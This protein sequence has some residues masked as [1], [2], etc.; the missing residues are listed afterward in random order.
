MY[1]VKDTGLWVA[2]ATESE[3]VMATY[4]TTKVK[5]EILEKKLQCVFKKLEA[6]NAGYT[7]QVIREYADDVPVYTVDP[8]TKTQYKTGEMKVECVEFELEFDD[9]KVGD[10]H[11]GAV[12]E[13]TE[14]GNLVYTVVAG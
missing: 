5:F 4:K 2:G 6:I 9:Y 11:V 10:F 8:I 14:D 3:G 12:L 13:K 1:L 7:F